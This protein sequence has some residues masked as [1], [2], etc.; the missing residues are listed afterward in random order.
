VKLDDGE[1]L[2]RC[3]K[4]NSAPAWSVWIWTDNPELLKA[5]QERIANAPHMDS[6]RPYAD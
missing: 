6:W 1:D 3:L 2:G 4:C 5:D